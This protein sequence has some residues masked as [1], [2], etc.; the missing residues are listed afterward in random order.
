ML[1]QKNKDITDSISYAKRIQ[2]SLLP[3]DEQK[4][5]VEYVKYLSIRGQTEKALEDFVGDNC[6]LLGGMSHQLA[7]GASV[8]SAREKRTSLEENGPWGF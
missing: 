8:M 4:A 6:I 3:P 2:D 7:L 5:L 1:E